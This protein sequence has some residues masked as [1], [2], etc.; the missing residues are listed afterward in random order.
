[1]VRDGG[2]ASGH[3]LDGGSCANAAW[4]RLWLRE[5]ETTLLLSTYLAVCRGIWGLARQHRSRE[6]RDR[7][8]HGPSGRLVS[9]APIGIKL[10]NQRAPC[11]LL[12]GV[13]TSR[14]SH[15]L[16]VLRSF[17]LPF[18][19]LRAS[20]FPPEFAWFS[21][22]APKFSYH[23][24]LLQTHPLHSPIRKY[25]FQKWRP[26]GRRQSGRR[27]RIQKIRTVSPR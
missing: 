3:V 20:F 5:T 4:L 1:V 25:G 22:F 6:E 8:R 21:D 12:D 17:F 19:F 9:S 24:I 13:P 18:Q 15:C 10:S 26:L 7:N 16:C 14:P 2:A 23:I 11:I 27:R